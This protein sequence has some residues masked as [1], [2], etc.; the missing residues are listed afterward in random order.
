MNWLHFVLWLAGIYCLYYLVIILIDFAGGGRSP[1]TKIASHELTFSEDVQPKI[2]EH[3][4]D[5]P[6]TAAVKNT[7]VKITK[8]TDVFSTGG[9]SLKD[10]FSL[11]KQEAI[12]YTRPVSF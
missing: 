9:V 3:E 8:E 5:R 1:G 10:L 12:F 4:I 6:E 2:L 7:G 11:A